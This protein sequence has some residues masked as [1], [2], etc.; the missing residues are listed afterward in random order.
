MNQLYARLLLAPLLTS[1][2]LVAMAAAPACAQAVKTFSIPS[3]SADTGLPVFGQQ[4]GT[5]VLASSADLKGVKT[6]AVVGD[7]TVEA[8]AHRL[9][10]GSPLKASFNGEGNMLV[11]RD[12]ETVAS[13]TPSQSSPPPAADETTQ[14]VVTGTRLTSKGLKSPTPLTVIS[15]DQLRATTTTDLPDALN[16]LPIFQGSQQPRRSG[17]G[18]G[19]FA[20]NILALRNFGA[21]RT[22]VLLDG[23]RVTPS[24]TNGTVDADTLP[25]ILVSRVDV[26]TGGASAVYGSDAVAGVVNFI[27]DDKFKGFKYDINGGISGYHDGA[28]YKL[29]AAWGQDLF[30][31][32]GHIIAAAQ[33]F[34]QEPVQNWDR[35]LGR[36]TIV[37]TGSG[38]AANPFIASTD[39]TKPDSSYGGR[40]SGC[41]NPCP[42]NGLQFT[43]N[44]V[45]GPFN[46]GTLTGTGNQNTGGDGA[47][48]KYTTAIVKLHTDEL[49]TRY[50]YD[51]NDTTQFYAQLSG[52]H[53]DSLGWH[54]PVKMTPGL[55]LNAAKTLGTPT[56][57]A[58]FFKNNAF[59]SP[60]VQAQ[61]GNNGLSDMSNVFTLG[62]YLDRGK[63]GMVGEDSKNTTVSFS[64]GLKGTWHS[65]YNWEVYY[66]HGDSRAEVDTLNN[67]NYQKQFAAADAV[68]GPDGKIHC[69]AELQAAT[70]AQYAGCVPINPF[71]STAMTQDA[72]NYFTG[73]TWWKQANILDDFEGSFAGTAFNDW[74]GPVSF[75]LS[76]EWRFNTFDFTSSDQPT[77]TVDCTGLRICLPGLALWAQ[78]T[79]GSVKAKNNVWE[80]AVEFGVPLLRDLPFA[81]SLDAN[82]A[83][84]YT[85]YSTSGIARTWK[86]GLTWDIS[87]EWRLRGT[88]SVDIRAPSL[89]DLYQPLSNSVTG[90][91]DLHTG[92]SQTTFNHSGGNPDL[93]PERSYD[94]TYGI[95]WKPKFIPNFSA[96][97]DVYSMKMTNALGSVAASNTTVQTICENSNGTSPLCALI[98]RPLPF[99]DHSAANF[100][101]AIYTENL[102]TALAEIKGSDVELNY[103]FN[104]ADL[105]PSWA[106]AWDF[107]FMG[108]AQPIN[109]SQQSPVTAMTVAAV[110]KNLHTIF[111]NYAV[112]SWNFGLEKRGYSRF[113]Q[114]TVPGQ[115]YADPIV[116]AYNILDVNVTRKFKMAGMDTQAYFTVANATN[117]KQGIMGTGGSIGLFFPIPL[118]EDI[119][120][121]YFTIGL[122]AKM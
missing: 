8:G 23:H 77:E 81:K 51:L 119:M 99:S 91:N 115:V 80:T 105:V 75:A 85:D 46:A 65:D 66:S 63:T 38:T 18:T 61:L 34:Q 36:E 12:S 121:R 1:A 120:G 68:M 47:Q 118:N 113:S 106:G 90:F 116:P 108:N 72:F 4:A 69:Y 96:S 117:A 111:V 39:V 82:I 70:H 67:S 58:V 64:T 109:R 27:L 55:T 93:V 84:R 33:H 28:S 76:G 52:A 59:L 7:F 15:A 30:G 6:N 14:V 83:G 86:L 73:T 107:R 94:Q 103:H 48:S 89:N 112:G 62:E 92:L 31:G 35:P 88:Q 3:Q 9:L 114:V 53:A 13:N 21:Q 87:D 71:G 60:T 74:A 5:Q 49:F 37:L 29:G 44:G 17:D 43:S 16:K 32:R 95:V 98:V 100:P 54:F 78:P 2:S 102:N 20:S 104:M 24:N 11:V 40:I 57:A 56:N 79:F 10:A 22:L 42:A 26:V 45:L 41:T 19:N 122:R 97:F 25:Q 110:P 101:T 50:N